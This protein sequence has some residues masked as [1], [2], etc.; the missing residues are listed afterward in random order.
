M[1]AVAII[2]ARGGSKRLPGK[3]VRPFMGKPL[4]TWT[5]AAAQAAP[6]IDR[7]YVS[8]DDDKIAKVA[9]KAGAV[10]IKRPPELATDDATSEDA[11]VHALGKLGKY[12]P[13]VLVCLQATSPLRDEDHIERALSLW[14]QRGGGVVSTNQGGQRNGA[15][16]IK[17]VAD[18]L[19]TRHWSPETF[20]G[21]SARF[22]IDID[23]AGDFDAAERV[24]REHWTR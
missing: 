22:S 24:A 18:F 12:K 6:S 2:C 10:V 13:D 3:N 19:K 23:S 8:T 7:V 21:M 1:K 9:K 5:I 4:I 20:F 17:S 14:K 11:L 16:Y 15:I